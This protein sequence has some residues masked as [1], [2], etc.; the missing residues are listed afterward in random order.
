M[1]L[2]IIGNG[3]VGKASYILKSKG[4]ELIMFDI[5]PELCNPLNTTIDDICK[6][7]IIMVCVP[8]PMNKDKSCCLN[9]VNSV[10]SQ[11]KD[12][13]NIEEKI[14]LLRSTVPPGISEKLGCYFMP[15]FLTE[16]NYANDFINNKEWIF[17]LKG[18][19][20][21][22]NFRVI[23]QKL[24]HAAYKNGVIK[25]NKIT[26]VSSSE[27][28][29]IK[30]FRN[31]FLALK[32]SFCNEIETYCNK[33]NIDYGVISKIAGSDNRIGLSHINVPGHDGKRGFG[34]TCFPKDSHNL[35]NEFK[36]NNIKSYIIAAMVDRNTK[37]DRPEQ[38]WMNNIGRATI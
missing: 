26:F 21:D 7:D 27:A 15:E 37:L 28:E 16:K 19:K 2:G 32:V 36:N 1:K 20:Q 24:I 25:S 22:N 14:V 31:N 30:L 3:F 8:T 6:C 38:D 35:L 18:T 17:G 34:G 13:I 33:K 5:L 10:V 23:I 11:L 29:M 12:I 4:I 9:I